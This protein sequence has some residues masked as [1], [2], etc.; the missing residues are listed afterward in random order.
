MDTI[1]AYHQHHLPHGDIVGF[2]ALCGDNREMAFYVAQPD[3]TTRMWRYQHYASGEELRAELA[4]R[5]VARIELGACYNIAPRFIRSL[6]T[7]AR[8]IT[9][10]LVFDIDIDAYDGAPRHA[11]AP[12]PSAGASTSTST[13]APMPT[14]T[15]TQTSG[16]RR[17]CSGS[18][19]CRRCWPLLACAA[20]VLDTVLRAHLG[21]VHVLHV[22]SGRRG[23][24]IW[25]CDRAA[26][27]LSEGGR[28]VALAEIAGLGAALRRAHDDADV[29]EAYGVLYAIM[30]RHCIEFA[31]RQLGDT[32]ATQQAQAGAPLP[33]SITQAWPSVPA[34]GTDMWTVEMAAAAR[35]AP[36][37]AFVCAA[38]LP[39]PDAAVTTQMTHLLRAPLVAHQE[40]GG[41]ALP[42]PLDRLLAFDPASERLYAKDVCA[43]RRIDDP[44]AARFGAAS[45]Y[46]RSFITDAMKQR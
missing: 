43:A 11:S 25:V 42:L 1:V 5:R 37:P 31:R 30:R 26:C 10:N 28:R 20:E 8:A 33:H 16:A 3:G 12:A 39:R 2:A 36:T 24:H 41:I 21:Y 4:R 35:G 27:D 15:P 34:D 32:A 45:Q 6:G 17:C 44:A 22:F 29:D 40:C 7:T 18:A 38:M 9:R 46:F 23:V 14:L 19:L 13:L